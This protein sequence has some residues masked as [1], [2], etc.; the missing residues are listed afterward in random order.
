[1]IFDKTKIERTLEERA[2]FAETIKSKLFLENFK[3]FSRQNEQNNVLDFSLNLHPLSLIDKK[4]LQKI[5]LFLERFQ[6]KEKEKQRQLKGKILLEEKEKESKLNFKLEKDEVKFLIQQL[7]NM[8]RIDK[9]FL[10]YLKEQRSLLLAKSLVPDFDNLHHDDIRKV[11]IQQVKGNQSQIQSLKPYKD[12]TCVFN[13]LFANGEDKMIDFKNINQQAFKDKL[14]K[15][16]FA[17][18][19][20]EFDINTIE[21]VDMIFQKEIDNRLSLRNSAKIKP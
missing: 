12:L 8:I 16:L 14:I 13:D 17:I 20:K 3:S 6:H 21:Q 4:Q 10:I 18:N 2:T 11:Y 1:M 19:R 7:D 5:L 9:L 15:D